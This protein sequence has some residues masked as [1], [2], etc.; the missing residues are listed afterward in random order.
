MSETGILSQDY[1]NTARLFKEM[2]RSVVLLK[3]QFYGLVGVQH[4]S[5]GDIL[6]AKHL[7][8]VIVKKIIDELGE[9]SSLAQ[10]N[11]EFV[12]IPPLFLKRLQDK[13]KSDTE[14]YVDDL[15]KLHKVF[16]EDETLTEELIH[17]LDEL[18]DQ[19]D[20][21]TT[22]LYRKLLRNMHIVIPNKF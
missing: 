16:I 2:N 9:N 22:S 6:S 1:T 11:N 5:K 18:C 12:E 21:E 10:Q 15:R 14:W 13:H 7:L 8:A 3:K 20:A 17:L 19:L 4:L